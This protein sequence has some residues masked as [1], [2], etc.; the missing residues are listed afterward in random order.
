MRPIGKPCSELQKPDANMKSGN[1]L[2]EAGRKSQQ[3]ARDTSEGR[4]VKTALWASV[5]R[6]PNLSPGTSLLTEVPC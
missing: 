6:H 4:L 2:L 3:A 1:A 5:R